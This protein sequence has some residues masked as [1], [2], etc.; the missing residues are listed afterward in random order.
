MRDA[1]VIWH[2]FL[3]SARLQKKRAALTIA[4]IAWGT[5]SLL[6]LLSFGEG[7]KRQMIRGNSGMGSNLAVLWPGETTKPWQGMPAGR[8]IRPKYE[9]VAMLAE[10]V[11]DLEGV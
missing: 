11:P 5:V 4:A 7:L 8:P 9:D 2:L 10:R 3:G 1:A 6:L